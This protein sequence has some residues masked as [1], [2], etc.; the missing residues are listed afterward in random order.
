MLPRHLINVVAVPRV[1]WERLH[2]RAPAP[3]NRLG[4][5]SGDQRFQSLLGGWIE[6]S[7]C[8]VTQQSD[9]KLFKVRLGRAIARIVQRTPHVDDRDA[10]E[11]GDDHYDQHDFKQRKGSGGE[12]ADL[13][14][15]HRLELVTGCFN[16]SSTARIATG[17]EDGSNPKMI[18]FNPSTNIDPRIIAWA[19][20]HP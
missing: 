8:T 1:L 18:L 6:P 12:A 16:W 15:G 10:R 13:F 7:F 20:S 11:Q 14:H 3:W 5:R 4:A 19:R 2:E 9:I 17:P